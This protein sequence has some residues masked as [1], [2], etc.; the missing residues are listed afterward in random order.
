MSGASTGSARNFQ[1]ERQMNMPLRIGSAPLLHKGPI[2][3][4]QT[5][6]LQRKNIMTRKTLIALTAVATLALGFSASAKAD[7]SVS[8]GIG[9]GGGGS[10]SFGLGFSDGYYGDGYHG[11]HHGYYDADYGDDGDCGY[12]VVKKLKWNYSHTYKIVKWTKVWVCN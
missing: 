11:Y 6:K 3:R 4:L 1:H 2:E 10:P 12:Q 7:P 5:N 8:F 9:F